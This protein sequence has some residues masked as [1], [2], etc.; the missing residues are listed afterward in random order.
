MEESWVVMFPKDTNKRK[1]EMNIS[2]SR[3]V[4]EEGEDFSKAVLT[5]NLC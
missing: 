5:L 3:K 2:P 1:K 4:E